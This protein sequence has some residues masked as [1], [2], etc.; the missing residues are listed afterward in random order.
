MKVTD[1]DGIYKWKFLIPCIYI[2][3]WALLIFGPIF[4][5]YA[6][7]IYCIVIVV[8][9]LLKTI[10][11]TFGCLV[12]LILLYSTLRKLNKK[13]IEEGANS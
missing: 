9:S 8:Y 12:A 2:I 4:F 10:G 6:Y 1:F 7:Q 11:L 3:S 13:K 5:P